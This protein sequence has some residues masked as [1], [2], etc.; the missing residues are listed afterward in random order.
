MS[1]DLI[2]VADGLMAVAFATIMVLFVLGLA[3]AAIWTFRDALGAKDLKGRLLRFGWAAILA[4]GSLLWV[5]LVLRAIAV[6]MQ[7]A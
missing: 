6:A 5:A 2:A 4:A 7:A 1:A 3:V